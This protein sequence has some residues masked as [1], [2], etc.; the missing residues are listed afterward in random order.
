M[1]CLELIICTYNHADLLDRVLETIAQQQTTTN[2][3]WQ[4]LVVNNNCTD[5]TKDV[6]DKHLKSDQI[7]NLRQVIEPIQGLNHARRCG[8]ENTTGD[9]LAF[10]DDDCLLAYDWVERAADFIA[11]Y[12]NASAFGGRV[13]LSWSISPKSYVLKYG[14]C[15][16]QQDHGDQAKTVDCLVGA[17]MIINRQAL[18]AT[19]WLERQYLSDRIGQKL[20]SGGDVELALRLSAV[21]ELWYN[22]ECQIEHYIPS[23]RT[24]FDYLWRI[25][26]G[27]GVSQIFGDALLWSSSDSVW[28]VTVLKQ[29]IAR[30]RQVLLQ[31]V[32]AI[33]GRSSKPKAVL[34]SSFVIGNWIGI[35]RLCLM[36]KSQ[37]SQILG[38][39]LL[40]ALSSKKFSAMASKSEVS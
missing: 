9:W 7:P 32:R 3:K 36:P 16:A 33:A 15:F 27:L 1:N 17:G 4:V 37:R 40:P 26:C 6:I 12:P 35:W 30:T 11:K 8:V 34:D 28:L 14:Y 25:N 20:V 22:P 2:I 21:G 39:A 24:T 18:L 5:N 23:Q 19:G 38:C 10:V 29:S 31:A 13:R